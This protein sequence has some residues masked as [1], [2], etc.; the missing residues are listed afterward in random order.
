MCVVQLIFCIVDVMNRLQIVCEEATNDFDVNDC[1]KLNR[2]L[3]TREDCSKVE[4][5]ITLE[6]EINNVFN[7]LI[8]VGCQAADSQR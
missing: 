8:G 2:F 4:N 6:E 3:K 7:L 5:G 1:S